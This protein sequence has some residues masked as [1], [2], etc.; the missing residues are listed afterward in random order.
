MDDTELS[1][2]IQSGHSFT[3][4]SN[5]AIKNFTSGTPANNMRPK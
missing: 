4:G 5:F 1:V 2:P 3:N